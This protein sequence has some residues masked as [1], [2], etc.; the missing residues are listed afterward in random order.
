MERPRPSTPQVSFSRKF[1]VKAYLAAALQ[2]ARHILEFVCDK[3]EYNLM[4]G[5]FELRAIETGDGSVSQR[6]GP[7]RQGKY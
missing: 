1:Q 2:A 6:S 4:E 7:F 3:A 5:L